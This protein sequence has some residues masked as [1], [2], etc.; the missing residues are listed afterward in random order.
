MT[1][2]N[3]LKKNESLDDKRLVV[4]NSQGRDLQEQDTSS[5]TYTFDEPLNRVSKID[6]IYSKIPNTFYNV[7][8]DNATMSITTETFSDT[9][10][11]ALVIDDNEIQNDVIESTNIINGTINKTNIFNSM[12][13]VQVLN[14]VTKNTFVYVAGVFSDSMLDLEDFTGISVK[15][16]LTNNGAMDLFVAQYSLEQILILRFKISGTRSDNNI[17]M[18]ITNT[19]IFL[20]GIFT[21]FPLNFYDMRDNISSNLISDGNPSAFVCRYNT[22]G[23]LIWNFRILGIDSTSTPTKIVVDEVGGFV[24][25]VGTYSRNLKIY[26]TAHNT[27]PVFTYMYT[28]TAPEIFIAK[29]TINGV[30]VWTSHI[31]GNC[32]VRS[33]VLNPLTRCP[34]FGIEYGSMLTFYQSD[35]IT[36]NG[37]LSLDGIQNLGIVEYQSNGTFLDVVKIGGSNVDSGIQLDINENTL[38]VAGLYSSNPISFFQ[39]DGGIGSNLEINGQHNNIFIAK[40]NLAVM[41]GKKIYTWATNIYNDSANSAPVSISLTEATELFDTTQFLVMGNYTSLLKFNSFD[42]INSTGIFYEL[43]QDLINNLSVSNTFIAN[44]D[45]NG[46]FQ[47]RSYIVAPLG[48]SSIGHDIDAHSNSL[49]I[50]GTFLGNVDVYNSNN[51]IGKTI[52]NTNPTT[53]NGLLV[54]YVNNINN[55]VIDTT[56]LTKRI[57][58][59]T[60]IGTDINYTLNL[61]AFSQQLGFTT[62]RKFQAMCF[63]SQINW[64]QLDVNS[65]NN[66]LTIIFRIGNKTSRIFNE[67][68]KVFS[69]TQIVSSQTEPSYSPFSLAFEL[70]NVIKNTLTGDVDVPFIQTGNAVIY[71]SVKKIFYLVF[72]IN[73]TFKV[74]TTTTNLAGS[75]GLN[76]SNST[77]PHC[78][79]TD[80]ALQDNNIINSTDNSKIS[81]QLNDNIINTRF[82]NESFGTAFK[83]IAGNSGL[84]VINAEIGKNL[85]ATSGNTSDKITDDLQTGDE[86]TF[87]APWRQSDTNENT[88]IK[89]LKYKDID[90]SS[91]GKYQ[92]AVV[93]DGSIY[94]SSNFGETWI[95]R[96]TN[97]KWISISMTANGTI[98]TAVVKGG[99][100]YISNNSGISWVARDSIRN[101]QSV[102][103]SRATGQYQTAV[104]SGGF[105][106]RSSNHGTSWI[107][108]GL[109]RDYID[110][111]ISGNGETQTAIV[112]E[113][114]IYISSDFGVS[115]TEVVL[116]NDWRG[117]AMDFNGV[118]Q[119]AVDST[120]FV[121]KS[122][123]N[124]NIWTSVEVS[125]GQPLNG[126]SISRD[127]GQYQTAVGNTG[128]IYTSSDSG[129]T[130]LTNGLRESWSKVSVSENGVYQTACVDEGGIYTTNNNG[131]DWVEIKGVN[132]WWGAAMSSDGTIQI[133]GEFGGNIYISRDSGNTWNLADTTTGSWTSFN[134]SADGMIVTAF[135]GSTHRSDDFGKT[136]TNLGTTPGGSVFSSSMS[137]DGRY[138]II[139]GAIGLTGPIYISSDFGLTYVRV[140][141]LDLPELRW[142]GCALSSDG[143]YM[144]VAVPNFQN[145]CYRS[146]NFGVNWTLVT[147]PIV[148]G[149]R[150]IAMSADGRYQIIVSFGARVLRSTDYGVNWEIVAGLVSTGRFS[151][152]MSA[153]GRYL[154]TLRLGGRIEI[155][156]DFGITWEDKDAD[157]SW[158]YGAM[159]ADGS[160]MMA[161]ETN[162]NIFN[163]NDFGN[164]WK[165][166]LLIQ[167]NPYRN[168]AW[169][170]STISDDGKH[171][172]TCGDLTSINSSNNYG[173]SF[174]QSA[175]TNIVF[176]DVAM[177][178]TGQYQTAVSITFS[179]RTSD[180]GLNW[181]PLVGQIP[182]R[183]VAMSADGQIQI[184]GAESAGPLRRSDN[185]GLTFVDLSTPSL[186]WNSIS[187]SGNGDYMF[188][189]SSG[190]LYRATSADLPT[191]FTWTQVTGLPQTNLNKIAT[192]ESGQ[193]VLIVPTQG[194][195]MYSND[196]GLTFVLVGPTE[197]S[198]RSFN[199]VVVAADGVNMFVSIGV[200]QCPAQPC[201]SINIDGNYIYRSSDNWVTWEKVGAQRRWSSI[202]MTPSGRQLVAT[203]YYGHIH[204]SFDFGVSWSNQQSNIQPTQ[205]ALSA[206]GAVQTTVSNGRGIYRSI[207]SGNTWDF[208][209]EINNWNN[210]AI[211]SNG[212]YQT[213]IPYNGFIYVSTDT[214]LTWTPRATLKNWRGIDMD[215]TGQ[216][217]HAVALDD[218]IYSSINFGA[219]WNNIGDAGVKKW[220]SISVSQT[221]TTISAV[222]RGGKIHVSTNSGVNFVERDNDRNWRDISMSKTDGTG[223]NQTAVVYGGKIYYSRDT[224]STWT[225]T[226]SVRNWQS[227]AVAGNGTNQIAVEYEGAIYESSNFGAT[228]IPRGFDK[229]WW[230]VSTSHNPIIQNAVVYGESIYESI[231][232]GVSWAIQSELKEL[233][234]IA[235]SNDGIRQIVSETGGPLYHSSDS[236]LLWTAV[237][238]VRNWQ[239]VSMNSSGVILACVYG[240]GIYRNT[241][242]IGQEWKLDAGST[243][244]NWQSISLSNDSSISTAVVNGGKIYV[245]IDG[246][247]NWGQISSVPDALWSGISLASA[248]WQIQTA[249]IK[250]GK[251]YRTADGWTTWSVV[252]QDRNWQDIAISENGAMQTALVQGGNIYTSTDAGLIWTPRDETRNWLKS[253][254]SSN[255]IKR[256]AVVSGGRIY[257]STDSGLTWNPTEN[258]RDW[259]GI[260][261]N[262]NGDIQVA[263]DVTNIFSHN[264]ELNADITLNVSTIE[265]NSSINDIVFFEE[266]AT[267]ENISLNTFNME[268]GLSYTIRRKEPSHTVDIYVPPGNYTPRTLVDR[269]NVLILAVNPL[270]IAPFDWDQA[271]NKITFT[272][273]YSGAGLIATTELLKNMG[274]AEIPATLTEGIG[275]TAINIVGS[276][277]SGPLNIFI[278]SDTIGKLKKN[279]TA[280]STNRNLENVIAPLELHS[281]TNT[282]RIP[283]P[284]EIFLSRKETFS[285]VDLQIVDELG[286][287]VNLNGSHV[288]VNFYFYS[289]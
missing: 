120:G 198:P 199:G 66:T 214:G 34:L 26:D 244:Q 168:L 24:Y 129:D 200:V 157:R 36:I 20:S 23:T 101:W 237:D 171:I 192:S 105:I 115:W 15:D 14:V 208:I 109:S 249:V 255:G 222:V 191:A 220:Q 76:L 185:F 173:I 80:S 100:V 195:V 43:G 77:S 40:Y 4:I 174:T 197:V 131:G 279:R 12:G 266:L 31:T 217:Q 110:I 67:F 84:L 141:L 9:S 277:L 93:E 176:R 117:I 17:D 221:G 146:E 256:I 247:A 152:S 83:S 125:N 108:R 44:Y 47:Y 116:T 274:F 65:V 219:D 196:F 55:Y 133:T 246:G 193:I 226:D 135:R 169:V 86:I 206:N 3:H 51:T 95:T 251:I 106:Y 148:V 134:M 189:C 194:R 27:N 161:V 234:S 285:T 59:R 69:I 170:S 94:V 99:Q 213:A 163:S 240:G 178:S 281:E 215:E 82:N 63:G 53:N 58:C 242:G 42:S 81:I 162:G 167:S 64:T 136:W 5:F 128:D 150:D 227:I 280:F 30:W 164:T 155:S 21:S 138:K 229:N 275:I 114:D 56:T 7:N 50:A 25:V 122:N 137:A 123:N 139:T 104:V 85:T 37:N 71:D 235:I 211:S 147:L 10:T 49:F 35:N 228:W 203:D 151:V 22:E 145:I 287:I 1:T 207:N 60:L 236:G 127:N 238:E 46:K 6:L 259:R 11:V 177:S 41:P 190:A 250:G 187:I 273:F 254:M 33:L 13:N 183:S 248:N 68:T 98:Q 142:G 28:G 264:F 283:M 269:I 132:S 231:D 156:S 2:L 257:V 202:S 268:D 233:T 102:S 154:M 75:T 166:R 130:W 158:N 149:T 87:K 107:T 113:G 267:I 61:N 175:P 118:L 8:N 140:P 245:T 16:S 252:E 225:E 73:G 103:I 18:Y 232:L 78:I 224:G 52:L 54:S 243:N 126:I 261:M 90:I 209:P 160:K 111:A 180:F 278:K 45:T 188:A 289:S 276:D 184:I 74:I 39:S 88:F 272:P 143:R 144:T 124:P 186:S 270:F 286:N 216:Y 239:Q 253:S 182:S 89:A 172:T 179:Y 91:D 19:D 223:I 210:I 263:C 165:R 262:G 288:Q 79:I 271:T 212:Q 97:R 284:I 32:V 112:F 70:S 181:I 72:D 153:S 92:T 201:S 282:F 119:M 96:E 159:S 29:F 48:G 260:A 205:T 62:S 121:Y 38:A 241:D 258:N 265:S 204:Q 57:I 230:S 218:Q